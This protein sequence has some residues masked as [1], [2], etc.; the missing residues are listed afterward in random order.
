MLTNSGTTIKRNFPVGK[1]YLERM[2]KIVVESIKVAPMFKSAARNFERIKRL[3]VFE[4][5]QRGQTRP[6]KV[7]GAGTERISE[8]Y[9]K[10]F[11]LFLFFIEEAYPVSNS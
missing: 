6:L 7:K 4:C 9:L 11:F 8:K 10:T 5:K 3:H 2:S 1:T